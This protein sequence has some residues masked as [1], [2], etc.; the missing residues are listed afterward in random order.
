MKY[1]K[2]INATGLGH[3]VLKSNN[4]HKT[5]VILRQIC[6]KFIRDNCKLGICEIGR[7]FNLHH[8]TVMYSLKIANLALEQKDKR[9]MYLYNYYTR[10]LTTYLR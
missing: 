6:I 4:Q 1:E 2:Y 3:E 5:I 8:S 9:F 10:N 7:I